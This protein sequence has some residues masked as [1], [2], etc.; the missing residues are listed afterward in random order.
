MYQILV[1]ALYPVR[2][3]RTT[4]KLNTMITIQNNELQITI[5]LKGAE[6]QSMKDLKTGRE[7][8]WQ[9]DERWWKGRAPILFPIVG[10]MWNGECR[11]GNT[12][13]RIPK[14][15]IMR[16]HTWQLAEATAECVRLHYISTVADFEVYPFAFELTL[17]YRLQGRTLSAEFQVKNN[18]S[19]TLWFQMG[20]HPSI[21]LPDWD[22][23]H[24]VDGYLK[25]EGKPESVWRAGD[26][27]CLEPERHPVPFD[28]D[29]LVPICVDTF[30]HEALIFDNHEVTAAMVLDREKQPVAR[31]ASDAACWLFWSPQGQHSPFVC[32]EPWHGLCDHQ[33]FEGQLSERPFMNHAECGE[34]WTGGYTVELF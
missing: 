1:D 26:Q 14:H 27:G 8:G 10:G 30:A 32:C 24:T 6:V 11:Y 23:S 29:G 9:G 5:S 4:L 20:G 15:G 12:V 13:L 31:V 25:L 22:E 7:Y 3:C 16:Q 21:A 2:L 17:T 33:H 34:T 28:A 18:G 19:S